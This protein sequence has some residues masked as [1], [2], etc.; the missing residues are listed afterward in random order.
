MLTAAQLQAILIGMKGHGGHKKLTVFTSADGPEWSIWRQN[1]TIVSRIN[2]WGDGRARLEAAAALEG[3][4]KM[5]VQDI[6][7]DTAVNIEALL[8]SYETRFRPESASD[9]SKTSFNAA[10]QMVEETPT[11]WASRLRDLFNRAYPRE[12]VDTERLIRRYVM[13]VK[14][15]VV[16]AHLYRKHPKTFQEAI[17]L[18]NDETAA[19]IILK[20]TESANDRFMG[21]ITATGSPGQVTCGF[22]HRNGHSE[23]TCRTKERASTTA[24]QEAADKGQIGLPPPAARAPA[25]AFRGSAPSSRGLSRGRGRGRGGARPGPQATIANLDPREV[26]EDRAPTSIVPESENQ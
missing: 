26:P 24:R 5:A 21:A 13:G 9:L 23:A 8:D 3:K 18:C 11:F 22:C 6:P 17:E 20:E 15:P 2:N 1:F 4:A 16:R 10:C 7:V 12:L 14:S 25:G 19:E